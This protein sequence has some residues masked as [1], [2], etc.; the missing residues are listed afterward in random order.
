M[1]QEQAIFK[2]HGT[3]N[4][5]YCLG[6]PGDFIWHAF[7]FYHIG[8]LTFRS[9]HFCSQNLEPLGTIPTDLLPKAEDFI[10]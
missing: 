6:K 4:S 3:E 7:G 10:G 1:R 9:K 2:N 5:R 8:T